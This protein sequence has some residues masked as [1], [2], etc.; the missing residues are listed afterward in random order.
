MAQQA[1]SAPASDWPGSRPRGKD[2]RST[3]LVVP[4]TAG[5]MIP[6]SEEGKKKCQNCSK[7][8]KQRRSRAEDGGGVQSSAHLVHFTETK[9][10]FW[11][12]IP[13]PDPRQGWGVTA[14][15]YL[16]PTVSHIWGTV[17]EYRLLLRTNLH[18]GNCTEV[19]A[20]PKFLA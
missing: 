20:G 1:I 3:Q 17:T 11:H 14:L 12:C 15:M 5:R 10:A 7:M 16:V 13:G 9:L 18:S 6:R 4:L 19:T 2:G 8:S